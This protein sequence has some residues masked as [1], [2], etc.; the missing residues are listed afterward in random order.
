MSFRVCL[1]RTALLGGV[2]LMIASEDRH[3]IEHLLESVEWDV[4]L[5]FAALFVMVEGMVRQFWCEQS[6]YAFS[7]LCALRALF[8]Y[9]L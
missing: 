2:A 8:L 1:R 6:L 7:V 9:A 3:E 4:L 5:F